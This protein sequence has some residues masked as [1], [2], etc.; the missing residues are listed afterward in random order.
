M[1][2]EKAVVI[3]KRDTRGILSSS[4]EIVDNLGLP[5]NSALFVAHPCHI[6]RVLDNA[7]RLSGEP[8]IRASVEWA[9]GDVQPWVRSPFLW[10]PREIITRMLGNK[11]QS[12]RFKN[13]Q[14]F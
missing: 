2:G 6:Q 8:F 12:Q 14:I 9:G 3:S 10:I 13:P 5:Y 1:K 7:G 11:S 4:K